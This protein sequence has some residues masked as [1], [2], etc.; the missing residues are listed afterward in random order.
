[1]KPKHRSN[2]GKPAAFVHYHNQYG[3]WL[4]SLSPLLKH[5]NMRTL[6]L[7]M[8]VGFAVVNTTHGKDA[9]TKESAVVGNN[10]IEIVDNS[11]NQAAHVATEPAG[12][13]ASEGSI[14]WQF[15][16]NIFNA[17]KNALNDPSLID[18]ARQQGIETSDSLTTLRSNASS[19][20]ATPWEPA[21]TQSTQP[22]TH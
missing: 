10:K 21:L 9:Q 3:N 13:A 4:I 20:S 19:H 11:H 8:F 12:H 15:V 22:S 6:A 1:M 5:V 18:C 17:V 7:L 2:H 16:G 14:L